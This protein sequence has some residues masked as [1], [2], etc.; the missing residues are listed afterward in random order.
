MTGRADGDDGGDA[1]G[2]EVPSDVREVPADVLD[3]LRAVCL[4][5][6]EVV[7]EEAWA[8]VRW[9]VRKRNFAH[10]VRIA[11]GW[12]PAYARAAGTEGP[13]CV[14]TFRSTGAELEALG[15]AGP[16]FFRPLW[17]TRW[18]PSVAGVVLGAGA[19]PQEIAELVTESYRLLAPARLKGLLPER[20]P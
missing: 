6:P 3:A 4:P 15:A 2:G 9:T 18:T 16:P 7:E 19:D 20:P 13:C 11:D 12:P 17:G 14:L 8:G 1:D 10:V 5:L